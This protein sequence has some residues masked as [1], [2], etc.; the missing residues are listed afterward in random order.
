MNDMKVL[1]V[2]IPHDIKFKF[3]NRAKFYDLKTQD[4]L[5]TLVQMFI[6]GKFDEIF[7]IPD[8]GIN[9]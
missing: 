3:S 5:Y 4:I 6:E 8:D 9:P 7:N 1:Q 2:E